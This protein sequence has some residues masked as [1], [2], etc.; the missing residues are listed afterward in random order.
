MTT[1]P[2]LAPMLAAFALATIFVCE[3]SLGNWLAAMLAYADAV[4]MTA[5]AAHERSVRL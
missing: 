2:V 5:I 1:H 3:V 4:G